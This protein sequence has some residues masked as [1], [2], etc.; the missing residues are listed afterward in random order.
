MTICSLG[1]SKSKNIKPIVVIKLSKK[2]KVE[3]IIRTNDYV[4]G[5]P[6]GKDYHV[7]VIKSSTN[8]DIEFELYNVKDISVTDFEL[9]KE[10]IKTLNK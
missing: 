2:A 8:I 7:L 5:S 4:N 10:E 1:K 3:D 6:L 9:F